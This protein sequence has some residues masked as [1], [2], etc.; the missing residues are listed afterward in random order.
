LFVI[1]VVLWHCY[2]SPSYLIGFLMG[3]YHVE[4]S[5][6]ISKPSIMFML[7]GVCIAD[8]V[9]WATERGIWLIKK[10]DVDLMLV[11]I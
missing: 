11:M 3:Q 9:V 2:W 7:S 5:L 6:P 1:S 10:L 4:L 8:T